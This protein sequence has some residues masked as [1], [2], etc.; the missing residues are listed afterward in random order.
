MYKALHAEIS[1]NKLFGLTK[2]ISG[3]KYLE[4]FLFLLAKLKSD[5]T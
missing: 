4:Q 2:V 3:R 5:L 1:R